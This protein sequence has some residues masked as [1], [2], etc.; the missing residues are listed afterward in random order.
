MSSKHYI[1]TSS[2]YPIGPVERSPRHNEALSH[3]AL[4]P[5]WHRPVLPELLRELQ[6]LAE[7]PAIVEEPGAKLA[8]LIRGVIGVLVTS[9]PGTSGDIWDGKT[10]EFW[11]G[12]FWEKLELGKKHTWVW[13]KILGKL[14]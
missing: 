9:K 10:G 13:L 7:E 6:G 14:L 2:K 12:G 1:M 5:G 8:Q 11:L 3:G 4:E